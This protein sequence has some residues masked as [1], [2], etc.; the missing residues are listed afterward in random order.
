MLTI[1]DMECIVEAV[2]FV[3]GDPV[4]VDKLATICGQD[5]KTMKGILGQ[6]AERLEHTPGGL[7]LRELEEAWQLCTKP[8]YE[9]YIA[10]LGTVRRAP[11][12]TQAAYETLSIIAYRQPVTR[13]VIEQIRGVNSDGVLLK[14]QEKNMVTEV[15]RDETPGRPILYGTTQEFLRAFGFR[16]VKDLPPL[17]LEGMPFPEESLPL[18]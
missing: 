17:E 16:S 9:E 5:K 7:L 18:D 11:G 8:A 1:K 15:G 14:L 2:L 12:L 3:A 4:P 13:A 6:M 10:Q